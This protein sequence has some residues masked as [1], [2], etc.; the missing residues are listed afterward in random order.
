M[1]FLDELKNNIKMTKTTLKFFVSST[2]SLKKD[3][4]VVPITPIQPITNEVDEVELDK[5][6]GGF[7]NEEKLRIEQGPMITEE[8]D[9]SFLNLGFYDLSSMPLY[10]SRKKLLNEV[11]DL[12]GLSHDEKY[13][14]FEQ[15]IKKILDFQP[16]DFD[17][18]YRSF[19]S[20]EQRFFI[21]MISTPGFLDNPEVYGY[22][23]DKATLSKFGNMPKYYGRYKFLSRFAD[24]YKTH[25]DE[26]NDKLNYIFKSCDYISKYFLVNPDISLDEL[27]NDRF[28]SFFDKDDLGYLY[29]F[30]Y[31]SIYTFNKP[32]NEKALFVLS[33]LYD[34]LK[35][36]TGPN[37]EFLQSMQSILNDKNAKALVESYY[38]WVIS[39]S[40]G[41]SFSDTINLKDN[42]G[43]AELI[44][45]LI[46]YEYDGYNKQTNIVEFLNNLDKKRKESHEFILGKG[47]VEKL[48]YGVYD[49]S[50]IPSISDDYLYEFKNYFLMNIYGIDIKKAK[51]ITG[52]YGKHLDEFF[53]C[54]PSKPNEMSMD[55]FLSTLDDSNLAFKKED[56]ST[57]QILSAICNIY[58]LSE[59][60]EKIDEKIR[61]L[62]TAYLKQAE[63]KGLLNKSEYVCFP[64]LENAL[65]K[66]FLNSFSKRLLQPQDSKEL[67]GMHDDVMLLDAGVKFDMI[68][69][70]IGAVSNIFDKNVNMALKWNT[71]SGSECQGICTSHISSQ[72][73]GVFTIGGPILGFVELEGTN[74]NM[75]GTSDIWTNTYTAYLKRK[76]IATL[77]KNRTFV[78]GSIMADETRYGYNELLLDRFVNNDESDNK[79]QPSYVVYFKFNDD[80]KNDDRFAQAHKIAT[81]FK[82][83]IMVVDVYKIKEYER[84]EI[85]KMKEELFSKDVVDKELVHKIVTRYMNNYVGAA[86]FVGYFK[87]KNPNEYPEDFSKK[88]ID[89]FIDEYLEK[90]MN[91][92]SISDYF[93]WDSAL[94]AVYEEENRKYAE[95]QRVSSESYSLRHFLLRDLKLTQRMSKAQGDFA[96]K[97]EEK[98]Q[99]E[100]HSS[101]STVGKTI[102]LPVEEISESNIA[103]LNIAEML[104][105]E[106]FYNITHDSSNYRISCLTEDSFEDKLYTSLVI[107]YLFENSNPLI[108][109]VIDNKGKAEVEIN[110]KD[111]YDF[112]GEIMNSSYKDQLLKNGI[113]TEKLNGFITKFE[114]NPVSISKNVFTYLNS[115]QISN[116]SGNLNIINNIINKS[117]TIRGDFEDLTRVIN[118]SKTNSALA[119]ESEKKL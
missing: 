75:M 111:N 42:L 88:D 68:I 67:I 28:L 84:Q 10:E 105:D 34:K 40:A 69:T 52:F 18:F 100:I 38:D 94:R 73:L 81:D 107:S 39:N 30:N 21:D 27:F 2:M 99:N 92:G 58:N 16:M 15:I 90:A 60:D 108:D 98:K 113:N 19:D 71:A 13:N 61:F 93:E 32:E 87:H 63:E 36:S 25:D 79:L 117:N 3:K 37:Y 83:P 72:N 26:L 4:F 14:R 50:D 22:L 106:S 57:L 96:V 51:Y 20:S 43:T 7:S 78:P 6:I 35:E 9:N 46:Y 41:K 23:N 119:G 112:V 1:S 59:E 53:K 118:S 95:S 104:N 76:N 12:N 110:V 44:S 49:E 109:D 86:N 55:E 101:E 85:N 114:N 24:Y 11:D 80:Y 82:V 33:E 102:S 91:S 45:S 47:C 65:N 103:V 48:F 29:R 74:L 64:V 97:M 8:D 116:V 70:S 31:N 115:K 56:Y 66:L 5:K 77:N 17:F 62:Q 89:K 54:L